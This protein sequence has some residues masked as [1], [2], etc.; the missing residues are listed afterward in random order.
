[1]RTHIQQ[2]TGRIA[3]AHPGVGDA[4][5]EGRPFVVADGVGDAEHFDAGCAVGVAALGRHEE[6]RVAHDAKLHGQTHGAAVVC[7]AGRSVGS[8]HT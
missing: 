3:I 4:L 1:M 8:V 2:G 6:V 7:V 5:Q